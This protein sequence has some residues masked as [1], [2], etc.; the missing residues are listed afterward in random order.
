MCQLNN[1]VDLSMQ[2]EKRA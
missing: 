1:D 2:E